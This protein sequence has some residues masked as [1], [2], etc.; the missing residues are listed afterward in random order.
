MVTV[1]SLV[2]LILFVYLF[3]VTGD[4]EPKPSETPMSE[5]DHWAV[6]CDVLACKGIAK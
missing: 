4:K 6:V 5:Y 1:I 2:G 3:T